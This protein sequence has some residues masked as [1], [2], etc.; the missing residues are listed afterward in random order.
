MKTLLLATTA[1]VAF[2]GA[3]AA[4]DLPARAYTKAPVA[5]VSPM[6]DWS[7]FYAGIMGGYGWSDRVTL[8]GIAANTGDLRGGF[9]GGTLGYNWQAP[10]SQVVFGLEV[11][12]AAASI[13]YSETFL[14]T[15]GEDKINAFGSVTGRLG[16]AFANALV[17]A[18]GGYGFANNRLAYSGLLLNASDSR[19][20]SGWTVGGGLE[21]MIL[22]S[23]SAKA[24]Y[25]YADYG[26]ER[27]FGVA[28]LKASTHTVKG[29]INYHFNWAGV[30]AGRY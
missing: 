22:P 24:E 14:G 23:W 19:L 16:Y 2:A 25:M 3:A 30:P 29:G 27:Y 12:A 1:L 9:V 18:K 10:G 17:Y 8:A 20:H 7:G 11:D 4:A 13:R 15:T 5:A 26:N 28:D 21:Y 6:T